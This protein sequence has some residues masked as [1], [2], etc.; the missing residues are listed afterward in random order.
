[1]KLNK[2]FYYSIGILIILAIWLVSSVIVNDQFIVP[3][4]A[5]T[6]RRLG[7]LLSEANTYFVIL[8]TVGVLILILLGSFLIALAFAFLSFKSRVVKEVITPLLALLKIIPLPTL[9]ILLLTHQTRANTS[10]ILTAFMTIPLMYDVLYGS[11]IG[12][13]QDTLDEIKL[14][15]SFNLRLLFKVYLPLIRVGIITAF[16]QAF[17]LGLKVKV[18][19]E[20]VANAPRTVGYQLAL[21]ASSYAMDLVFAWTVLLVVLVISVDLIINRLLKKF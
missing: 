18:M 14:V 13:N 7:N 6:G 16:L 19:T 9:I 2:T 1:M 5:D 10:I 20:Y 17:G 3:S 8:N 4:L 12:I 15:S 11:L 21:A